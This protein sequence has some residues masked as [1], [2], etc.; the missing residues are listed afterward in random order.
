MSITFIAFNLT[1][2]SLCCM[3]KDSLF[4][5]VRVVCH[6]LIS[7]VLYRTNS[8]FAQVL[9]YN[10]GELQW[11][12]SSPSSDLQSTISMPP[13]RSSVDSD[14]KLEEFN[15]KMDFISMDSPISLPS[16]TTLPE[17]GFKKQSYGAVNSGKLEPGEQL[18][19]LRQSISPVDKNAPLQEAK[20]LCAL[21]LLLC[22][23]P[24]MF[25]LWR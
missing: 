16:S 22:S 12:G 15:M 18:Q 21:A 13:V 24:E 3:Y 10:S 25:Q 9:R 11:P 14:G 6:E 7:E 17:L 4:R 8:S 2:N 23:V 20:V 19:P 5:E 1:Q